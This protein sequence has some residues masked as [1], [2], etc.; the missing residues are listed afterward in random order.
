MAKAFKGTDKRDTA[1]NNIMYTARNSNR[2]S[3][4]NLSLKEQIAKYEKETAAA[5]IAKAK[6][7]EVVEQVRFATNSKE[8]LNS[9]K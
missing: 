6:Q 2:A 5:Q 1:L 3:Q 9:R 8:F 7:P 4:K